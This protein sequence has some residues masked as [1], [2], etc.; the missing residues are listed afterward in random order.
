MA[1]DGKV[2][3]ST[4][5]DNSG[6]EKGIKTISGQLGGLGNTL[7]NIA[8]M[9]AT[10]FST[11]KIIEFATESSQDARTMSDALT[12]ISDWVSNNQEGINNFVTLI[13]SIGGA[14]GALSIAAKIAEYI[15]AV[16]AMTPEVGLLAAMFPKLSSAIATAG[17]WITGTLVPAI[18]A[19]LAG[20]GTA[21]GISVGWVL[22]IVAAVGAAI[23]AVVIYWDE[24]KVFFTETIPQ[25]WSR[26]ITW[27]GGILDNV[28]LFFS[29]CWEKIKEFFSPA[30]EWFSALFGSIG[31]AF[32]NVFYN[33]GVLAS[34][35]WEII[36]AVWGIVSG[37]FNENVVQPVAEFVSGLWN[38][39]TEAASQAWEAVKEIFG[40]VA[41]FFE[42]VFSEAWE[43]VVAVFSIAGDIF[44]DIK[45]GILT[46]FKTVVNGIIKGLNSAI[47][48]PFNEIN[49]A[50]QK[51][52]DINI[53]GMTPFS[54]IKTISVPQI[55]YLA[56]GAVIPPN[57]E[58]M[59]VLGDQRHG[60][61]IE[62][63][64]STIQE[65][66]AE[67]MDSYFS[68]NMAGH[69][70]TVSVLRD[71]LEAVLG[72]QIGDDMIAQATERYNRKMNIARGGAL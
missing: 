31:Q 24:I 27:L 38:G 11:K 17:T 6:F 33:I 12:R 68:A 59:A 46:A 39:F 66:V 56:Q 1:S 48:I 55:P 7:K 22:A 4:E 67:V 15:G 14:F 45:D 41:S 58:F 70:A 35:C 44:T 65:A 2:V 54:G 71:I 18:S 29:N 37:W 34:G 57:R 52:K 42:E 40:K 36:K 3:I 28:A 64:L 23:A 20:I 9:L 8:A 25:L 21:L 26:F 10:A 19:A 5:L 69:E 43:G 72:I 30:A 49:T 13:G 61:N 51:I 16:G 32:L 53:L 47:S 62:A 50:L 63:P 60:T